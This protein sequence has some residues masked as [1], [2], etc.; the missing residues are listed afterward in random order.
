VPA[1]NGQGG[2]IYATE[3]RTYE[4]PLDPQSPNLGASRERWLLCAQS[5]EG[6]SRSWL[7]EGDSMMHPLHLSLA[8]RSNSGE[9]VI[10]NIAEDMGHA[11]S[12]A[13]LMR[14]EE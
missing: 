8:H 12:R 9:A 2:T 5:G 11:E 13:S 14:Y 10:L 7:F 4:Y 3:A 1:L 6:Y